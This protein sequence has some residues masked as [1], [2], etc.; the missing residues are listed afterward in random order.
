MLQIMAKDS[1]IS[2]HKPMQNYL[3]KL[4]SGRI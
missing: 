1:G 2:K 3:M 4:N